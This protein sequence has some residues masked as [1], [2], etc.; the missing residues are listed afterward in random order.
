MEVP[1]RRRSA[2]PSIRA[3]LNVRIVLVRPRN[4]LNIGAAA[5]AMANFGLSDLVVVKPY[6]PIWR[7]TVSAVGAEK[8]VLS[9]KKSDSLD[10]A[11]A[12][13]HLVLGT[14]TG[15][16][17]TVQRPVVRLPDLSAYIASFL[18]RR[19]QKPGT[20]TKILNL[21]LLFGSEKTGLTTL[22]LERCHALLTVPTDPGCPSMNLGQA[23]AVCCYELSRAAGVSGPSRASAVPRPKGPRAPEAADRPSDAGEEFPTVGELNLLIRHAF[24][25]FQASRFLAVLPESDRLSKIRRTFLRWKIRRTDLPL[26]HGFFRSLKKSSDAG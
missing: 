16:N 8:L 2:S 15:R 23:V 17:R 7:E 12:D 26:L 5:R 3:A 1:M 24:E 20:R 21:A 10:D 6:A 9:A 14:T 25:L 18:S 11:L 22:H 13:R 4:P 19:G